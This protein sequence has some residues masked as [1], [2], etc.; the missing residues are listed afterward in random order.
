MGHSSGSNLDLYI[1]IYYVRFKHIEYI[2]TQTKICNIYKFLVILKSPHTLI[3][4]LE[5]I[6]LQIIKYVFWSLTTNI[7]VYGH[8]V[9][10]SCL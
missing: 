3:I 6:I 10:F 7:N 5:Q 9:V 4:S 8:Q 1:Y 2:L